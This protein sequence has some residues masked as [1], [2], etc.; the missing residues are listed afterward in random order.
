MTLLFRYK[1]S[2]FLQAECLLSEER[3]QLVPSQ[4]NSVFSVRTSVTVPPNDSATTKPGWG[5]RV[6]Q[7]RPVCRDRSGGR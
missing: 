7:P 6:L 3:T 2:S 1:V 4:R 5:C